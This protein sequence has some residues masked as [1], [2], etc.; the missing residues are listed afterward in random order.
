MLKTIPLFILIFIASACSHGPKP[1]PD[2]NS[3]P[4]NDWTQTSIEIRYSL[5]HANRKIILEADQ[6]HVQGESLVDGSPLKRC[7]VNIP[8]YQEFLTKIRDFIA[9]RRSVA[10][11]PSENSSDCRAP[12]SI[13]L[14]TPNDTL[15][16]Q[17]CRIHDEGAFSH[18]VQDGEFLIY[19]QK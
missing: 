8:Q 2:Q 15:Q 11:A 7:Q 5:R 14:K 18:L 10:S 12:Y 13:Q 16:L 1:Q 9:R 19:R 3:V 6:N 4:S 17:G